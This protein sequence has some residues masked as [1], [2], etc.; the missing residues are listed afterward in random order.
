[1]L[2]TIKNY[3][4]KGVVLA[5]KK[6]DSLS[7]ASKSMKYI[8]LY[9]LLLIVCCMFYLT[10]WAFIW[11]FTGEPHLESLLKFIH[12]IASAS[13]IAVIGFVAQAFVDKNNNGIPDQYEKEK[14][15][16]KDKKEIKTKV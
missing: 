2:E 3:A 10:G 16:D 14:E 9:A 11:F 5:R 15:E 1:M 13:W 8:S 7:F 4:L 6:V 12:E